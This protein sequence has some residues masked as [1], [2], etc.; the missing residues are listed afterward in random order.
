VRLRTINELAQA[1]GKAVK[2]D[3]SEFFDTKFIDLGLLV[4][5]AV[6]WEACFQASLF[7]KGNPIPSI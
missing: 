5:I 4:S 7:E 6:L 3:Y 2:T 1:S